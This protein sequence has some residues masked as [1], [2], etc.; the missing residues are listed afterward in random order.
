MKNEEN[1][2]LAFRERLGYGL[3]DTASNFFFQTFNIFLLYYYTDVF[4]IPAAAVGTMFFVTKLWDA[5]NDP[6]MGVIADRTK[7][8]WGK[9]RP[10]LLWMAVPYGVMGYLMFAG[11]D[12][13]DTGKLI[14]AW[15]TYTLMMM[16]YTA[17]NVPYSALMGVM[18][19]SSSERTVLSSFRFVGAFGGGLLISML[20]RPMVQHFG[21][22]DEAQGFQITMAIFAIVSVAMF[23]ATF[24]LCKERVESPPEEKVSIRNDL[25]ILLTTRPWVVLCFAGILT[26]TSVALRSAVTIHYFK[27]YVEDDGGSF[28]W[29]FD[30]TSFFLTI[31]SLA[32]IAGVCCTKFLTDRF[33]KKRLLITLSLLNAITGPV[34]FFIPPDQ[35]WAMLAVNVI[36]SLL[37]GPTAPIVWAM[38]GDVADYS[39]WKHNRRRTGLV[40]QASIF[41]QKFGLT[42]GAGLSGWLLALFGYVANMPQTEESMLG[43][44]LLFTFF[45]AGIALLNVFALTFYS[46][47]DDEVNMIESELIARKAVP[48]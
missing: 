35:Y 16:L 10:Y 4:G 28:I 22:E 32:L 6:L 8:R 11:P 2:G 31:G 14:Y 17:I 5:I 34:L 33:D 41:A 18:T 19:P 12:I 25:K 43:I 30:Q 36:G 1:Q 37:A 9:F 13:N 26:L 47:S 40:F 44:R 21:V 45:P 7:T 3:G 48:V 15:V 20:V 24:A 27:Y 46:L 29:F 39:E 42:I 38:Y 23:W